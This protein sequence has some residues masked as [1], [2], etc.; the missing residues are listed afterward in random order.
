PADSGSPC[1]DVCR[2][3]LGESSLGWITTAVLHTSTASLAAAAFDEHAVITGGFADECVVRSVFAFS[4]R[5]LALTVFPSMTL[6][7]FEHAIASVPHALFV[8][9]GINQDAVSSV[10]FL[11]DRGDI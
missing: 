9:G 7:R 4:E 11:R 6:H 2:L 1:G 8:F 3:C 10:E 5:T